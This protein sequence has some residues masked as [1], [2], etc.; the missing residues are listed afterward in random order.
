MVR[1]ER[2]GLPSL[3]RYCSHVIPFPATEIVRV[4]GEYWNSFI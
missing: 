4:I 1:V 2:P 3:T